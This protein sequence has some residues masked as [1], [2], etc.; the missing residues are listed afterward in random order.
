MDPFI[1]GGAMG[2][3]GG[4]MSAFGQSEAN[5]TAKDIA[6][7]QME[8]QERMS[9]TAY[10]R[11]TKDM[12]AAGINPML[13]YMQGGASS[14]SGA[15]ANVQPV[16]YGKPLSQAA[17]SAIEAK[18]VSKQLE[19]QD[20]QIDQTKQ[21]TD[22]DTK[23][24][25]IEQDDR[26]DRALGN[27]MDR[28]IK[29]LQQNKI[30]ADTVETLNSGKR[31]EAETQRIKNATPYE[32]E[33]Y[34]LD[35]KMLPYDKGINTINK[36]LEGASSAASIAKPVGS[37]RINTNSSRDDR[38]DIPQSVVDSYRRSSYGKPKK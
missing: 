24:T 8:F 22:N 30:L 23:R 35:R 2:L 9:N 34:E 36:L 5:K 6:F 27:M 31:I 21:S 32:K 37:L 33:K 1:A 12:K 15:S 3:A 28:D 19:Q 4:I 26:A 14:P 17:A 7:G 11:A 20:A 13:A 16:D 25:A 29:T 38:S 10:Q 18:S